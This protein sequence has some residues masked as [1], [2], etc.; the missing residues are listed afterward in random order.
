MGHSVLSIAYALTQVGADAVGGSEQILTLLDEALTRARHRSLVI[1]A[2]GSLVSGSLIPGPAAKGQLDDPRRKWGQ[3]V[4][5]ELIADT[6]ERC[7]VDLVHMHSLDFHCY[8]PDPS[9]PVLATLHLPPDWYPESIFHH[10]RPHLHLNCVSSSQ[11]RSCPPCSYLMPYIPNGVDVARFG[12]KT[13]KQDFAL[14]LGRSCPEEGF[15][16]A[17]PCARMARRKTALAGEVFPY[18]AHHD[19]LN[20]KQKPLI[21]HHTPQFGPPRI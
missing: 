7:S 13:P 15:H 4:Q 20:T 19:S 8:L 16:L 3:Q 9:V 21:D 18:Y 5:R 6:L 11:Q 10:K 14:G 2:E 12:K 1:A 17:L